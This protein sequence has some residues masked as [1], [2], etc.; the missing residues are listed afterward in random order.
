MIALVSFIAILDII[1]STAY[2]K[3]GFNVLDAEA[4]VKK[5]KINL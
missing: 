4:A 2:K 3:Y 5:A 1:L